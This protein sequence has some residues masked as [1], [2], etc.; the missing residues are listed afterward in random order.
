MKINGKH[1]INILN[2]DEGIK[3]TLN[4]SVSS[5]KPVGTL[6]WIRNDQHLTFGVHHVSFTF[7]PKEFDNGD[8][9]TCSAQNLASDHPLTRTIQLFVNSK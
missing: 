1:E 2:V 9:Y 6:E 5:G 4:C 3:F 7:I 8:L